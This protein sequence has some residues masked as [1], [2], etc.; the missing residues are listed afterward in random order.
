[1]RLYL[2]LSL[3]GFSSLVNSEKS[4]GSYGIEKYKSM[5]GFNNADYHVR[6]VR[7]E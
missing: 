2:I 4:L 3:V 1:M 6:N 7:E 5:T